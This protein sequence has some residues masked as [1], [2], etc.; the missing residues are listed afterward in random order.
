M[1]APSK[2]SLP[3]ILARIVLPFLVLHTFYDHQ[4]MGSN[5]LLARLAEEHGK[6]VACRRKVR[7]NLDRPSHRADSFWILL[8]ILEKNA[9]LI[10]RLILL[11]SFH[12]S[13]SKQCLDLVDTLA[14]GGGYGA[15][16]EIY[17]VPGFA[18]GYTYGFSPTMISK[19][20]K[21]GDL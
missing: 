10:I 1:P 20:S 13:F 17:N 18:L 6:P 21:T 16:T 19:T 11:G 12:F 14:D 9:D 3:Q 4:L 8:L 7:L 5:L 2:P 15:D